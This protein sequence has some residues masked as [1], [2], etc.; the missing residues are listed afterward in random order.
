MTLNIPKHIYA[1]GNDPV[2]ETDKADAMST[3]P[4]NVMGERIQNTSGE[5]GFG[6]N[7]NK[8]GKTDY[9]SEFL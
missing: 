1:V 6:E 7:I 3:T 2:E 5:T 8:K 9:T 4:E